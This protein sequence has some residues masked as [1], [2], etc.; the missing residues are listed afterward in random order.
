MHK[1]SNP[2]LLKNIRV[3]DASLQMQIYESEFIGES[4]PA[5]NGPWYDRQNNQYWT[6]D[7]W[8]SRVYNAQ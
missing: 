6:N 3:I 7:I 5:P 4:S 1:N 2:I 8:T